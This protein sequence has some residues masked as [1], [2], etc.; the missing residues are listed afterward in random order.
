MVRWDSPLF[1]VAWDEPELPKD[2]IWLVIIRGDIK[3]AN[4]GTRAV[5]ISD[6]FVIDIILTIGQAPRAAADSLQILES[7]AAAVVSSIASEQTALA[8]IGGTIPISLSTGRYAILLPARAITFSELQRLKRAFVNMHKKAM[9]QGA[10]E[11]SAVEFTEKSI[12]LK[13]I[14]Y[15]EQ[16]MQT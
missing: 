5:S 3:P 11:R 10:A 6:L 9:T 1:T 12:V 8:G 4:V 13:F 15:L 7:T 14:E 16:N 2:Q